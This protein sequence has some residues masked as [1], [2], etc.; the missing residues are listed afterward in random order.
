MEC[1]RQIARLVKSP[2]RREKQQKVLEIG[3]PTD[4]RKEELPAFFSDDESVLSRLDHSAT[5]LTICSAATLHSRGSTLEKE[6]EAAATA[7]ERQPSTRDKIKTHVRRLSVRV[8]R[9][10]SDAHDEQ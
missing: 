1:F 9:P 10:V 6:K 8:A 7:M 5:H 4:F 3:P 2:F